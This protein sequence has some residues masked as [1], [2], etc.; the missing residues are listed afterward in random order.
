MRLSSVGLTCKYKIYLSFYLLTT[1]IA[2]V[3]L[4]VNNCHMEILT[5]FLIGKFS[6]RMLP[7]HA[8]VR[9]EFSLDSIHFLD[10]NYLGILEAG[11]VYIFR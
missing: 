3:T 8:Y 10:K 2:C 11:C 9:E 6:S 4:L 5:A 7:A 1:N